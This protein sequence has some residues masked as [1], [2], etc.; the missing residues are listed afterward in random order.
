MTAPANHPYLVEDDDS[1]TRL[2]TP[3]DRGLASATTAPGDEA[4]PSPRDAPAPLADPDAAVAAT[5]GAPVDADPDDYVV[6]D[7]PRTGLP[8]TPPLPR[9]AR[10]NAPRWSALLGWTLM[11]VLGLIAI[12]A[13]HD[14]LEVYQRLA[15]T[16]GLL[17]ALFLGLLI[18]ACST[19]V[20]TLYAT[21][22]DV[23]RLKTVLALAKKGERLEDLNTKARE[24]FFTALTR[25]YQDHPLP[26]VRQGIKAFRRDRARLANHRQLQLAFEEQVLKPLDQRADELI[27]AETLRTAIGT[28]LSPFTIVDVLFVLWRNTQ[29]IKAVCAVYG[30]RPG[31]VATVRLIALTVANAAFAIVSHEAAEMAHLTL[32]ESLLGRLGAN[33]TQGVASGVL[34]ARLGNTARL[35]CR[36]LPMERARLRIGL[37]VCF[38]ALNES[39]PAG[40]R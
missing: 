21:L 27:K 5:P 7:R 35:S 9:E 2:D 4:S 24:Q 6:V 40:G 17:G 31:P 20:Y 39:I 14:G 33:L 29:L 26:G 15:A 18:L 3:L 12:I 32:G 10:R 19:V 16:S 22:A 23:G 38:K 37:G 1:F 11:A 36:P 30:Y 25:H 13:V 34:T 28:G 8:A